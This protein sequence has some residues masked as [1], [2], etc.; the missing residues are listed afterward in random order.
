MKDGG[1]SGLLRAAESL[2]ELVNV[3]T[4]I[5]MDLLDTLL[6]GQRSLMG[7]LMAPSALGAM[8]PGRMW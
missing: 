3:G 7:G 4:R 2:T 1:S 6:R 5:G 8:M